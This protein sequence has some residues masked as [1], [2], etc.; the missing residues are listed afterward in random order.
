MTFGGEGRGGY[1]TI[2]HVCIFHNCPGLPSTV[3]DIPTF[4][5]GLGCV[6]RTHWDLPLSL[7]LSSPLPPDMGVGHLDD[8]MQVI[9]L[10][11]ASLNTTG[12]IQTQL[13]QTDVLLHIGDISYA[14]GYASV[15]RIITMA[16]F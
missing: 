10:Q 7:S 2:I 15:V 11:Q 6:A 9:R 3:P 16:F 1:N 13:N 14:R 5:A 4:V 8:T 12:T